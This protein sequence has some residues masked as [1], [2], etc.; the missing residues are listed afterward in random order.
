M[1]WYKI[2]QQQQHLIFNTNN[3]LE[4]EI[5]GKKICIAQYNGKLIACA[6]T[7]P[8]AGAALVNGY[9]DA[10][11]NI[12]CPLHYYKFGL[13][14]AKNAARQGYFLKKYA[15]E[16]RSDGIFIALEKNNNNI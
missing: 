2:A 13:L 3:L 10:L 7:C 16:N 6:A 14:S 8:H 5:E 11:G 4:V 1:N 15:I 12:V 9:I